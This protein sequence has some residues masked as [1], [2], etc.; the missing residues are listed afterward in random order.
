MMAEGRRW[1]R[2]DDHERAHSGGR[3][4]RGVVGGRCGEG[5]DVSSIVGIKND[6]SKNA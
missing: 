2:V 5:K 3:S 1:R 6:A 4:A